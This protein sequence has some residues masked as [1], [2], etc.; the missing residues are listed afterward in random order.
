[1]CIKISFTSGANFQCTMKLVSAPQNLGQKMTDR[2]R[3]EALH[4]I[5]SFTERVDVGNIGVRGRGSTTFL[6]DNYPSRIPDLG[7]RI[8]KQHQKR[9]VKKFIVIPFIVA[10]NFTKL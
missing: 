10:T 6:N 5:I 8:Q 9:G 7:S 1:M 2:E 4:F 3:T